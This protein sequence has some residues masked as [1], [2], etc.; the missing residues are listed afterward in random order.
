MILDLQQIV[1][2]LQESPSDINE[3]FPTII[4]YGKKCDH[5]TEIVLS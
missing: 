1:T 2:N 4:K 3:H 5:I